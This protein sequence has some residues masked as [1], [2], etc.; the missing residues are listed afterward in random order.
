MNIRL[1]TTVQGTAAA[2]I[3][4]ITSAIGAQNAYAI[5]PIQPDYVVRSRP[6]NV[7]WGGLPIGLKP[8]MTVR[9]GTVVRI[10]SMTQQGATGAENPVDYYGH[11][12]VQADEVLQDM[13]DFWTSRPNRPNYGG[14]H[15]LTGPVYIAGAEPGDMLEVQILNFELRVPYGINSTSPTSGVFATTYPGW[16]TGDLNLDIPAALPGA[17]GGLAPGVRQQFYRTANVNGV[18]V[19]L[20]SDDIHVPLR[21]FA[22]TIGVARQPAFSSVPRPPRHPRRW[23]CNCP[24][25]RDPTAATWTT[26]T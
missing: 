4:A 22:G 17:P 2:T 9:P 7:V 20:F 12:G 19:A 23:A 3:L 6:E 15:V 13:V 1:G 21:P 25:S 18:D 11:F 5:D 14:G 8:A 26:E 16:R 10:E 24:P